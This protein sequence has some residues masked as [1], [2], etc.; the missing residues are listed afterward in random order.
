MKLTEADS[1]VFFDNEYHRVTVSLCSTGWSVTRQTVGDL[2]QY[3]ERQD[4]ERLLYK[5]IST[6]PEDLNKID[7]ALDRLVTRQRRLANCL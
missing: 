4:V 3:A 2:L 5:D 1:T 7:A 6:E